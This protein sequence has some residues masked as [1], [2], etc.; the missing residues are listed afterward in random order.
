VKTNS[1]SPFFFMGFK[2]NELNQSNIKIEAKNGKILSR[3][4]SDRSKTNGF[5]RNCFRKKIKAKLR[6]AVYRR[7]KNDWIVPELLKF[8]HFCTVLL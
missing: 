1:F 8:S 7:Q 2:Q 3:N 4:S 6:F 5:D